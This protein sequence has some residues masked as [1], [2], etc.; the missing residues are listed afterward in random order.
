MRRLAAALI[1]AGLL[2]PA[3]AS[4]LMPPWAYDAALKYAVAE[5]VLV[6]LDV[7]L[8][9][10]TCRVSGT[11]SEVRV[12]VGQRSADYP[13]RRKLTEVPVRPAGR[14]L[15]EP[16]TRFSLALAC[17]SADSSP[18][19]GGHFQFVF[20]RLRKVRALV[21]PVDRNGAIV[22]AYGAGVSTIE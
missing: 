16:G 9:E 19:I 7:R 1:G 3:P 6:D 11:V 8:D 10:N 17:F 14:M 21:V 13:R 15:P 22:D 18:V 5:A 2:W 4:A 20:E 12:R